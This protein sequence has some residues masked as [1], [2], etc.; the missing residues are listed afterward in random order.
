MHMITTQW[1]P[2]F[3]PCI[4]VK[5]VF[6]HTNKLEGGHSGGREFPCTLKWLL[7][8]NGAGIRMLNLCLEMKKLPFLCCIYF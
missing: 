1:A 6:P 7:C 4:L 5:L 3:F 2:V 8:A